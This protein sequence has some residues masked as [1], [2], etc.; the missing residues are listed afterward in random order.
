MSGS[1]RRIEILGAG[2]GG[3][4]SSFDYFLFALLARWMPAVC[5]ALACAVDANLLEAYLR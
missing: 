5:A 1:G 3:L 4:A 2:E